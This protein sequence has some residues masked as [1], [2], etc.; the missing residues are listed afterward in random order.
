MTN[1]YELL[2][3]PAQLATWQGT[4]SRVWTR[5]DVF[6][7]QEYIVGAI[8]LAGGVVHDFRVLSGVDR[9]AC[10][11]GDDTRP[12][13]EHILAELRAALAEARATKQNA[14]DLIL[15]PSFRLEHAGGLRTQMPGESLERMLRDGTIPLEPEEPAGKRPRFIIRPS[16]QVVKEVLERVK[17]KAGFPANQ[18]L[19]E[20][21]FADQAHQVDVNLVTNRAAG[22]VA[23]GWYAGPERI[24]L[25]FLLAASKVEAYTAATHKEGAALF[26]RR[27]TIEDGL[28]P[29]NWREVEDKLGELEWR[30]EQKGARVVTHDDADVLALEVVAWAKAFA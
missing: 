11:Y 2:K 30:L 3:A 20:D 6:S 24:Q 28:S 23:S 26:F 16:F 15:P 17:L 5:P 1:I 18:F 14:V 19:R 10:I 7:A 21:H 29:A 8:S 22:I 12:M 13:F 9:L 4:W 25:E 27:P